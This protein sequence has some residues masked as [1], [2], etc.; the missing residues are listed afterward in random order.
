MCYALENRSHEE[1]EKQNHKL[2][3]REYKH[4]A[5]AT[6]HNFFVDKT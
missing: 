4:N 2:W 5:L 6:E 3:N 1:L